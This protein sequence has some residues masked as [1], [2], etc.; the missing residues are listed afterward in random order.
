MIVA[1]IADTAGSAEQAA[2][3]A[4]TQLGQPE[5][6]MNRVANTAGSAEQPADTAASAYGIPGSAECVMLDC[7]LPPARPCPHDSGKWLCLKHYAQTK[8]T[9]PATPPAEL[10][11]A[12]KTPVVASNVEQLAD[13]NK[14]VIFGCTLPPAM[15]C[16]EDPSEW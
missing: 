11:H 4:A 15:P 12:E 6:A 8:E 5:P 13:L 10:S 14:C 7:M 3:T 2:D 9:R 16:P 1:N